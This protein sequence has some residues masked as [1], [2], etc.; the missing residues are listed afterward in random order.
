MIVRYSKAARILAHLWYATTC[1]C[2]EVESSSYGVTVLCAYNVA[3]DPIVD[4]SGRGARAR[5]AGA[6]SDHTRTPR[7]KH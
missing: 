6:L 7:W 3:R 1:R 4:R 5:A 2:C